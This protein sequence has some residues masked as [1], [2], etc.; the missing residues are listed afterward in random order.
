MSWNC[1]LLAVYQIGRHGARSAL[2]N[3][4]GLLNNEYNNFKLGNFTVTHF[5]LL[6]NFE[7]GQQIEQ[8]YQEELGQLTESDMRIRSSNTTRAIVSAYGQLLG[9]FGTEECK[10][11]FLNEVKETKTLEVSDISQMSPKVYSWLSEYTPLI[12]IEEYADSRFLITLN[13]SWSLLQYMIKDDVILSDKGVYNEFK[14]IKND[15]KQWASLNYP[16]LRERDYSSF[17]EYLWVAHEHELELNRTIFSNTNQTRNLYNSWMELKYSEL[18][19]RTSKS[20]IYSRFTASELIKDIIHS[21]DKRI[22]NNKTKFFFDSCHD[23]Q[24]FA[25]MYILGID[26]GTTI[27]FAASL[28]IELHEDDINGKKF[29]KVY[30]DG[31]ELDINLMSHYHI[32]FTNQDDKDSVMP[33][34]FQNKGQNIDEPDEDSSF[35]YYLKRYLL[36]KVF[37][38]SPLVYWDKTHGEMVFLEL[39][40]P[41]DMS[42]SAQSIFVITI[43]LWSIAVFALSVIMMIWLCSKLKGSKTEMQKPE[44][45]AGH[46]L[47][48]KH[49]KF[50]DEQE[51]SHNIQI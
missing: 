40:F 49:H 46:G 33:K 34:N 37:A 6:Q 17:W 1:E 25:I 28:F 43:V 8:R 12:H 7:R 3:Y 27:P 23:D 44:T 39:D 13:K 11:A 50:E 45:P 42:S 20:P 38:E 36:R 9:M 51:E 16:M 22:Q 41:S 24:I 35:Y 21:F 48:G 29:V 19:A 14:R 30:I 26:Y 31:E 2:D 10:T 32:G 4:H 5:G 15:I 18:K 47:A